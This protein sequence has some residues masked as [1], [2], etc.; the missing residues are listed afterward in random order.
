MG[1]FAVESVNHN[2]ISWM[3]KYDTLSVAVVDLLEF[4]REK[5][6]EDFKGGDDGAFTCPYHRKLYELT[7]GID[8]DG[9]T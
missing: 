9:P 5:Y 3:R 2:A 8:P 7:E 6:P 4:I 1:E